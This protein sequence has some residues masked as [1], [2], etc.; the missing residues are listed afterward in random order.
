MLHGAWDAQ[1]GRQVMCT[2]G[3]HT[4][5]HRS[6]PCVHA[7]THG[8]VQTEQ[9]QE[10]VTPSHTTQGVHKMP[11]W[12]ALGQTGQPPQ[13]TLSNTSMQVRDT[14][15][16]V[17]TQTHTHQTWGCE[18]VPEI[19]DTHKTYR[20]RG[21]RTYTH[22]HTH[23]RA[24]YPHTRGLYTHNL[25]CFP[26]P[27]L[28]QTQIPT[29]AAAPSPQG[30]CVHHHILHPRAHSHTPTLVGLHVAHPHPSPYQAPSKDTLCPPGTAPCSGR[31]CY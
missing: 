3:S 5:T 23:A 7:H 13:D 15:H 2:Q 19:T 12:H 26:G 22:T 8:H 11:G 24:M 20:R 30:P 14:S 27:Q 31:V 28:W 1:R 29:L 25:K 18:Q 16:A 6:W 17:R 10:T 9:P 21:P 4:G